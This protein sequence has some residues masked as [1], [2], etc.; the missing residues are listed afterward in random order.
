VDP[1]AAF[2]NCNG[3]ST[4]AI[5]AEAFGGLGN[6]RFSLYSDASLTAASLL[7]G[8]QAIGEFRNLPAGTYYVSVT[9]EDCTAPAEE[10][11]ITEP[12]PL[13]YTEDIMDVTC[14]GESDGRI[15]VTL[16]G[17]AGGYQYAISPNLSQ[18]DTVNTFTDLAPGDYT[19]IAQDQNGCFEY[20]TYTITEPTLLEASATATPEICVDSADGSISLNINGGTAPYRTA[21]NANQEADF[22]VDRISFTDLAAGNYLIFVRDANGCETNVIVDVEPGVDLNATVTP[23]YECTGTVPENY[24]NITLEDETVLGDVMYALDS[25]DPAAL[26][27]NPDFRNIA[28]GQHY[29]TIAHANG[30]MTTVDFTIAAFEPLTLVLEQRNLNEITAL[31]NGG[32]PGYTYYFDGVDNGDD[33]TFYINR[34]DTYEVRVVDENGCEAMA[35][36][37]MEFIDIEIPNFFTPDGDGQN[38]FWMPRNI[39]QFPEIL[40]KIFDRYGRVVSELAP[41]GEG[42]DGNYSG[43]ELPTGDYWYVIQLNGESDEREFVGHFTLYR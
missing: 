33:N 27:L 15:T 37:F 35:N 14:A 17:G 21:I 11:V 7:Q 10:V 36:I 41:G 12:E 18:F 13:A 25:I 19:I 43:R 8:P 23:V 30:C 1:S 3:E 6:Y 24:V 20:L 38:D 2:I 31:G 42:W 29:I 40:I 5:Y 39:Q 32:S 34:T 22:V 4:A 26:Q 9:S 28:P 16:S